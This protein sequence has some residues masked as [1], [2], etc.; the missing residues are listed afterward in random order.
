MVDPRIKPYIDALNEP[1]G[2]YN[3]THEVLWKCYCAHGRDCIDEL[4]AEHWR[5]ERD[6]RAGV[7]GNS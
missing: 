2:V 7:A 6:T 3:L 5:K 4:L 1:A